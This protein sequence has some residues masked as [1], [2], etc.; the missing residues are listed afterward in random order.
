MNKLIKK[1]LPKIRHWLMVTTT[2]GFTAIILLMFCIVISGVSL[3][4]QITNQM[5]LQMKIHEKQ[6]H[7]NIIRHHKIE[8]F[9]RKMEPLIVA[10][11]NNS[12]EEGHIPSPQSME[13]FIKFMGQKTMD[14]HWEYINP[15]EFRT[16]SSPQVNTMMLYHWIS[17]TSIKITYKYYGKYYYQTIAGSKVFQLSP[18]KIVKN[19]Q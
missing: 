8:K 5:Q 10:N 13:M 3:L 12:I 19:D 17:H 4:L 6:S 14:V 11:I 16:S 9:K 2:P 1:F 15:E 7:L 18:Y